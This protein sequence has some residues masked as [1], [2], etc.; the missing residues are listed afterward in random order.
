MAQ[1]DHYVSQTYLRAF[2]NEE[3]LLVPY[4]KNGYVIVGK[5]KNTKSV[6][7]E[8]DG[9]ANSYFD[10]PRIVDEYLRLF[11][12]DWAKHVSDIS[13]LKADPNTK[14]GIA[15]YISFLRTCNPTAK[16]M[17]QS[18]LTDTLQ[19]VADKIMAESVND[20]DLADEVKQL[21][22]KH[23]EEKIIKVEVDPGYA[24]AKAI[25]TLVR[26]THKLYCSDWFVLINNT[27]TPFITSDNPATLYYP[28][29][30]SQI[31]KTYVP[32]SPRL[33]VLISPSLTSEIP[34]QE[35]LESFNHE[36]DRFDEVK[37]EFV[38]ILNELVVKSAENIVIHSESAEWLEILVNNNKKW[39]MEMQTT[40]IPWGSGSLMMY[41]QQAINTENA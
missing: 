21:Y 1:D 29:E 22:E 7:H 12:N 36:N 16:R 32:L 3:G 24:H 33:G 2:T 25:S 13:E 15:G 4:Y 28:N 27:D 26:I 23:K 41:R 18:L 6:C 39:R 31:A 37:E 19:P 11:E 40:T 35:E 14:Y 17:G 8:K 20:P 30:N 10:D 5:P 38:H 34:T 9:D